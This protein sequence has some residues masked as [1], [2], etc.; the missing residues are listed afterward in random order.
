MHASLA[1]AT[2]TWPALVTAIMRGE[3]IVL[4]CDD[5]TRVRLVAEVRHAPKFGSAR[6]LIEMSDDFDAPLDDMAEYM[7]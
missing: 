2:A 5:G 1:D 7:R 4:L 6:G 3:P